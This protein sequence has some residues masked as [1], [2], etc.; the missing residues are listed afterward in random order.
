[1]EEMDVEG[2]VPV[3]RFNQ[4]L[5]PCYASN[6]SAEGDRMLAS[7][8]DVFSSFKID[9]GD[10]KRLLR[11]CTNLSKF[12]ELKYHLGDEERFLL[13]TKLFDLAFPPAG[14]Q[15]LKGR[16]AT[17]VIYS[18]SIL[19]DKKRGVLSL[20]GRLALPWR[21]VYDDTVASTLRGYPQGSRSNERAKLHALLPFIHLARNYW[22]AGADREIWDEVKGALHEVQTQDAF[23]ALFILVRFLPT[24]TSLYEELLPEWFSLWAQV[25]HCSAWDGAWLTLLVRARKHVRPGFDWGPFLSDIYTMARTCV[26]TPVSVGEAGSAP[27]PEGRQVAYQYR[28]LSVSSSSGAILGKL[29][30]LLVYL[31][32]KGAEGKRVVDEMNVAVIPVADG[33]G[34]GSYGNGC[35]GSETTAVHKES[36]QVS[37]GALRLIALLRALR[38]YFHPSNAGRWSG[39]LGVLLLSVCRSLS[40]RIGEES[41]IREAKAETRPRPEDMPVGSPE[42]T[43]DDATVVV[44]A[45]LPLVHE[46]VYSKDPAAGSLAQYCLAVL[47]SISP[48]TVAAGFPRLVLNAL[49]PVASVNHAHQAPAAIRALVAVF[50]LLMYPRPYLAPY[51]PDLLAY[52]LPGVDPNDQYKTT[53]TLELCRTVLSWIPVQGSPMTY[54]RDLSAWQPPKL[55][56]LDAGGLSREKEAEEAD[57]L[58]A[59]VEAL[60][61]VMIDWALALLDRVLELLRHKVHPSKAKAGDIG[62][63]PM[64]TAGAIAGLGGVGDPGATGAARGWGRGS[65]GSITGGGSFHLRSMGSLTQQ[66]FEQMDGEAFRLASSR[67]LVF[68]ME[69]ARLEAEKDC[70]LLVASCARAHPRATADTFLP[71]LCEGLLGGGGGRGGS[72]A[73]PVLWRW[74]LRL[75]S[76]LAREARG[77]LVPHGEVLKRTIQ[78]GLAHKNKGTRKA[79]RKVLKKALLGL[80]ELC[81][82]ESRSLPPR[83]WEEAHEALEWRRLCEPLPRGELA[84]AWIEPER[85]GLRLAAQLVEEF[86]VHPMGLLLQG[87]QEE[88]PSRLVLLSSPSDPAVEPGAARG[89]GGDSKKPDLWRENLKTIEYA[90]RGAITL[91]ADRGTLGPDKGEEGEG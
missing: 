52:S 31:L 77:A 91:L 81:P 85:P 42:L 70:A 89:D 87:L 29:G 6:V 51:L 7:I 56:W 13:V 74:R 86:L 14:S 58:Y 17:K 71:A 75:L 3:H 84:I 2:G 1:M 43:K 28:S 36:R 83:R 88:D 59:S 76:G 10:T 44:G 8:I 46:M 24:A 9:G 60:H 39:K 47:S 90:M 32:G 12:T 72:G 73:S 41:V 16:C 55:E 66:L 67:V 37:V 22:V 15:T 45:I 69:K 35:Y 65:E 18:L 5:P 82:A 40:K 25:D 78:G 68:V 54:K 21:P 62:Q 50:R 27:L 79:A 64:D 49:D 34:G 33:V 23:L 11:A 48:R 61:R 20:S 4:S 57:L 19:M 80:L 26:H 53:V 63:D 38:T 30:K